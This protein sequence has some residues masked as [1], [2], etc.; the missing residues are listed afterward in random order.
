MNKCPKC[1]SGRIEAGAEK[2]SRYE[3]CADC[4]Y[5]VWIVDEKNT[6]RTKQ[7]LRPWEALGEEEEV[8]NVNKIEKGTDFNNVNKEP[9]FPL[10]GETRNIK[11][12]TLFI[13]INKV[14]ISFHFI[15]F[16]QWKQRLPNNVNNLR[17]LFFD[18]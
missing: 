3:R 15:S 9:S 5:R 2:G 6:R 4:G 14:F 1:G 7:R 10:H 16:L 18:A 13:I 8:N 17:G 11:K 12:S